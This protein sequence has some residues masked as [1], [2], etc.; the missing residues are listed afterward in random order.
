MSPEKKWDFVCKDIKDD[1]KTGEVA[2]LLGCWPEIAIERAKA[3]AK[4][5]K[6][7]RVN[8]IVASGGVKW[9]YCGEQISEADLMKRVLMEDGVPEDAILLDQEARTTK[10]NMLCSALVLNR[11]IKF[12]NIDSVVIV[13]SQNH[14]LRSL[15]LAK[16]LLPRKFRIS[17]FPSYPKETREEWL[18]IEKNR[19]GLDKCIQLLKGLVDDRIVEDIDVDIEL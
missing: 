6:A 5:Y 12:S 9:E 7:G 18:A 8:Y 2:I 10:E 11:T 13:T 16:A 19:I 17:G 4:L 3:A 1:G 15:A 14:M